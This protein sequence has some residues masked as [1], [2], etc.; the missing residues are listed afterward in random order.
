MMKRVIN[1]GTR[2]SE[3]AMWQADLVKDLLSDIGYLSTLVPITSEGDHDQV[4]P[5]YEMGVQ[6]IFTKSLDT[7]LL[8]N[9]I[10]IAVHSM[11][12][13]PTSLP[14]GISQAAVLK[15]GNP[16]DIFIINNANGETKN[17]LSGFHQTLSVSESIHLDEGTG[18][19]FTIATSSVRRRAQWL[20]RYPDHT[21]VNLRGNINTRMEKISNSNWQGAV[22][23]AAGLERINLRPS[24]A[25]ELPWMLPAP[26]QGAIMIVCR[27]NDTDMLDACLKL[28]HTETAIC[29][30]IEKDF[31]RVLLGGC[32]TPIAALALI[33]KK[34][35]YFKGNILTTDGREKI[36]VEKYV[37]IKDS[38]GF[39]VKMA[40]ELLK[41]GGKEIVEK[42]RHGK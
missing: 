12:D 2:E 30:E 17:G 19:P 1:I 37:G 39:G 4:T 8:N 3:L 10:D 25:I 41:N 14:P 18:G 36:E 9:R 11:K 5:L 32:S 27:S 6:G 28:N 26:A 38:A 29:T 40:A 35:I 34:D 23:A 21:I 20:Q 22:L 31:L 13:V 33:D 16:S 7:A 42:I 15:R 24:S